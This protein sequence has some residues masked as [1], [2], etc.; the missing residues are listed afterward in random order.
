MGYRRKVHSKLILI[1]DAWMCIGSANASGRSFQLDSE[2]NLQTSASPL[3]TDFRTRL[4]ALNLGETTANVSAWTAS[5]FLARWDGV[6]AKNAA[7]AN[8]NPPEPDN[9]VGA[10]VVP[11]DYRSVPGDKSLIIPDELT[12]LDPRKLPSGT[13]VLEDSDQAN[14]DASGGDDGPGITATG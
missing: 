12:E 2:L 9:M 10:C 11:F 7:F 4:W 5:D 8:K 3:I 1:D 13:T 6:A 14:G